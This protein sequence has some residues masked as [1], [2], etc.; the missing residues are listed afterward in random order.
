[1]GASWGKLS[2]FEDNMNGRISALTKCWKIYY[3]WY[4]NQR[5]SSAGKY[6]I[7]PIKI[8][9]SREIENAEYFRQIPGLFER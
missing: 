7:Y 4:E 9:V 6:R 8:S 2:I 3:K 1:M 5:F